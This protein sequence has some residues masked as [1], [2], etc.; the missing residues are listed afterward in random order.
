MALTRAL[1]A[2]FCCLL[3]LAAPA[4]SGAASTG[5]PTGRPC[6]AVAVPAEPSNFGYGPAV[7]AHAIWAR[8]VS[9]RSA[10]KVVRLLVGGAPVTRGWTC[11]YVPFNP[12]SCRDSR[13]GRIETLTVSDGR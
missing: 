10:R 9:C 12:I 2:A 6:G 3:V 7:G 13:G 5:V 1:V 8:R 11:T 4:A